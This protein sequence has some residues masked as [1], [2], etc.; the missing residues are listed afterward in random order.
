MDSKV[1]VRF[2]PGNFD[3]PKGFSESGESHKNR[4]RKWSG[5]MENHHFPEQLLAESKPIPPRVLSE[6]TDFPDMTQFAGFPQI[7][8]L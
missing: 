3:S 6:S 2:L 7:C 1:P 4:A 5:N 8:L